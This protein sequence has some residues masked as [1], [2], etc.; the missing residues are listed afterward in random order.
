MLDL[1][2]TPNETPNR[3]IRLPRNTYKL[4]CIEAEF[5]LSS[6]KQTPFIKLTW[7]ITEPEQLNFGPKGTVKIAGIQVTNNFYLTEKAIGRLV[8]FHKIMGLPQ[9]AIDEADHEFM[10]EFVEQYKGLAAKGQVTA[11][12]FP[13]TIEVINQETGELEKQAEVDETGKPIVSY[14]HEVA[15]FLKREQ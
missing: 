2:Q 6:Q 13:R 8:D 14:A 9:P 1:N 5:G 4:R 15:T 7:E 11:R 10:K 12:E 3:N